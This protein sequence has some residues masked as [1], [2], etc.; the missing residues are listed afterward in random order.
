M[1][2]RA[3]GSFWPRIMDGLEYISIKAY[4][5]AVFASNFAQNR[6]FQRNIINSQQG[7]SNAKESGYIAEVKTTSAIQGLASRLGV[8]VAH[9]M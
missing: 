2:H 7:I 1:L 8:F 3:V 6:F 4:Y 9:T 5:I